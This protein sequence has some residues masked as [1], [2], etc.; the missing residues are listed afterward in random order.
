MYWSL[1]LVVACLLLNGCAAALPLTSM[2]GSPLNNP[3]PLQVHEQTAV[4]LDR[5]NFE[6]VHTNAYGRSRGFALFGIFTIV[7]A[8]L[9]TAVKRLYASAEVPVGQPQ[10]LAHLIIERSSSYYLL[11]SIPKVEVLADIIE[12]RPTAAAQEGLKPKRA[13]PPP[14]PERQPNR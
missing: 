8:T 3:P 14:V 1:G 11:F 2:I 4:T 5:D 12:Y 9:T 13:P 6:I 10:T 7:P